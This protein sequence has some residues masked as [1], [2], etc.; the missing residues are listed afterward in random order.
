MVV[1]GSIVYEAQLPVVRGGQSRRIA[2]KASTKTDAANELRALRVDLARGGST[3]VGGSLRPSVA[4]LAA[5]YVSSLEARVG[6]RDPKRRLSPRTVV[7]YRDRLNAYVVTHLGNVRVD[8]LNAGHLRR[9]IDKIGRTLAPGTVTSTLNIIS[10]MLRY[11]VKQ[12]VVQRNVARDLDRD[13]RPGSR[14]QTEPRYLDA[15]QLQRLFAAMSD[16][17]RPVAFVCAYAALRISETLGLV[18]S[19]ID[20]TA[21]TISVTRQ[22][23]DDGS[24]RED[25]KTRASRATVP[26]LPALERELRAHRERV[27]GKDLRRVAKHQLVFQTARGKPQSRRNALRGV[28]TAGDAAGLNPDGC[29]RVGLHDLRHSVIGLALVDGQLSLAE[30]A[31]FARHSNPRV[32]TEMYAGLSDTARA[33][34]ATKLVNAGIGG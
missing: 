16:V 34:V 24:L 33:S 22:L 3:P 29:E 14:R 18:W 31:E 20:F 27:A 1:D 30:A 8:E 9:L 26:M 17:F 19:D 28:H 6:H 5:D 12:G 32:T 23:D 10:G 11:G 4:D 21:K 25:V 13:D 2:L 7:L 15:E